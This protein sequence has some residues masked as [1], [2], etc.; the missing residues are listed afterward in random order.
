MADE[1]LS[2]DEVADLLH[3]MV[4]QLSQLSGQTTRG[5]TALKASRA[6]LLLYLAALIKASESEIEPH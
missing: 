4:F 1:T 2:D 3:R 6:A 5:D